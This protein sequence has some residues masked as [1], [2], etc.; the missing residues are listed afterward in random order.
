[1][2]KLKDNTEV[3]ELMRPV[4]LTILT[5][6]PKK[7][8]ITDLETG[9]SYRATGETELYKQWEQIKPSEDKSWNSF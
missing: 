9:Q 5:K 6:G 2:R 8:L 4:N 3:E 1:M 7:W